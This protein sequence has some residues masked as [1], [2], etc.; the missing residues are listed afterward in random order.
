MPCETTPV[1]MERAELGRWAVYFGN[2]PV[3]AYTVDGS[4]EKDYW[5]GATRVDGG[6]WVLRPRKLEPAA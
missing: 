1:G 3:F 2:P 6:P 4:G 5:C